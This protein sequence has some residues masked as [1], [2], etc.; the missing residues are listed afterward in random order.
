MSFSLSLQMGTKLEHADGRRVKYEK[1]TVACSRN[2]RCARSTQVPA[3][4]VVK[5]VLTV[6]RPHAK[7]GRDGSGGEDILRGHRDSS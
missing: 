7:V 5:F 3:E 1:L 6:K 2:L 4:I